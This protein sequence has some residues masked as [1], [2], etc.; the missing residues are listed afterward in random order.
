MRRA[1]LGFI[2]TRPI[3]Y[4]GVDPST[5]TLFSASLLVS[6]MLFICFALYAQRMFRVQKRF[7]WYFIIGQIGQIIT[8]LVPYNGSNKIIHTVA[9]FTLAF[10]LP[11]LI[12]QFVASQ[13]NSHYRE[14]YKGLL[15]FEF[16]TF[17]SGISLFI[18]TSSLAP[19]GEILAAIGFHLWIIAVTFVAILEAKE[20]RKFH[21]EKN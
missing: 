8:A 10:S 5:S 17:G 16:I 9:G 2:D 3:S 15:W 20:D 7:L 21:A 12:Q 18:F 4:L 13:K 1:D 14:L 11:L 19:L 6:A